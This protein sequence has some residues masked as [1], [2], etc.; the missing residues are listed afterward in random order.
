MG[1]TYYLGLAINGVIEGLIIGLAALA[2][3]LV[4]AVARFPNAATGDLMTMGAYAGIAV[5]QA[6]SRN[7][8]LQGLAAVAAAMALSVAMYLFAFRALRGRTMLSPLLASIG[9]ALLARSLLSLFVGHEQ[10]VFRMPIVRPW[11]LAGVPIQANDLW[12]ACIAVVCVAVTFAVLFLTPIGRQMRAVADDLTLARASGIRADR[13]LLALWL[14]VGFICGV[15]GMVLGVRTVVMPEMG[16]NILLPAFAAAVLG[17]VGSPIGAV[18]AALVLGVAQ[19][20]STPFLGFTYKIALSFAVL[21]AILA[22]RP[23]GLFGHV[24]RVR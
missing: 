1:L 18:V 5:Q 7:L 16:W 17:G 3:N 11:M 10:Y 15:A 21:I 9:L 23:A 4:F 12:L 6:G 22:V 2:L 19:E 20:L 24:E 8:L 14:L 13:V